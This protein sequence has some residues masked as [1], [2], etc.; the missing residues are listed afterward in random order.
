[1]GR[2]FRETGEGGGVENSRLGRRRVQFRYPYSGVRI[3]PNIV[4]IPANQ[5]YETD[6][7]GYSLRGWDK[8]FKV[9]G[10]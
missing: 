6:K 4:E 9:L 3:T 2:D 8:G 5:I 1:M 10:E 7:K